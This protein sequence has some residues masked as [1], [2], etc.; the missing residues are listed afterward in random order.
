MDIFLKLLG[1]VLGDFLQ[2]HLVTLPGMANGNGPFWLLLSRLK[3]CQGKKTCFK[4]I[5]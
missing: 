1:F 4:N 5:F 2:A 3:I